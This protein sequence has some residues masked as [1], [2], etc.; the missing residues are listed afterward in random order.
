MH[1][2]YRR[3]IYVYTHLCY[4]YHYYR[5]SIVAR[6]Y[7]LAA[8]TIGS[9]YPYYCPRPTPQRA[10]GLTHPATRNTRRAAVLRDARTKTTS[11]H[12]FHGTVAHQFMPAMHPRPTCA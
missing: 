10:H 7:A 3:C 2:T 5:Y 1:A 9:C 11:N 8:Y 6:T 4:I 12:I